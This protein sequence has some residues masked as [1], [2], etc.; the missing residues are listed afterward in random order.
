MKEELAL[1]IKKLMRGKVQN[2]Y[3]E[4]NVRLCYLL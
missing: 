1:D 2:C 3:W 4:I